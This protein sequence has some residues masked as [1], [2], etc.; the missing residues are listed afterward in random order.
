MFSH[1]KYV[2][3]RNEGERWIWRHVQETTEALLILLLGLLLLLLLGSL[4]LTGTTSG[5]DGSSRSVG[6]RV[7]DAV[8]ELLNLGPRDLGGDSDGK[9]VLVRV[10]DGVHDRGQG[11]EVDSQRDGGNGVDDRLQSSQELLLTNVED[12]GSKGL[13]LVVDLRNAHTVGEGRDVEHVEQG[14]LGGADLATSLNELE[15]GGDFNGTTGNLGGDTEGL[16]E[17]GLAGLHTG[18]SSGNPDIG[19]S[20]STG[21]SGSSNLV[22]K[23]DITNLLEVVVGEDETDVALDEGQET[24]V[25]RSV[26][27]EGS[28]GTADLLER[29]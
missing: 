19:G 22:G 14:S 4:G 24:L 2:S 7:G 26:D 1:C 28:Q 29:R 25:L 8:L 18:V 20:E 9:D 6:I 13:A 17:G 16:E 11:G 10:D 23:D 21:T 12:V 3:T 27:D 15:I 5:S